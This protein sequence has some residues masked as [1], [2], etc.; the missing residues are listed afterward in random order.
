MVVC[1]TYRFLLY[2]INLYIYY[3][4]MWITLQEKF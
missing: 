1:K 2:S 4:K 3:T